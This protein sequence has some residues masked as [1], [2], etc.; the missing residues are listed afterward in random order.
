MANGIKS[1]EEFALLFEALSGAELPSSFVLEDEFS[2][3]FLHRWPVK[4]TEQGGEPGVHI[5]EVL[6]TDPETGLTLRCS[7]REFDGH[8]AVEWTS[9]LKNTGSR[10]TPILG[11]I[12]ALD[13]FFAP[14]EGEPVLHYARGATC[15]MDDFQPL[16]RVMNVGACVHLQP[17]GGRSSSDY[18]P[19]F[20]LQLAPNRGV[21][22]GIGW[23]GEWAATFER[24]DEGS[25]RVRI[26][27]ALTRLRLHP[28][29]EI[30]TPLVL[31]LFYEGEP[32][33]G[34]NALRRFILE[35]HRPRVNGQPIELPVFLGN[36]GGTPAEMHL[37]NIDA[38]AAHDLPA[39]FYWIDAEWFGQGPWYLTVGD[40]NPKADLYPDG[41]RPISDRLHET[42]RKLLLWFEPERV[43]QGT[44]WYEDLS[45]WLLEIPVQKRHHNWGQSQHDPEWVRWESQ[46]N[47]IGEGDRLF[48][49]GIPKARQFLTDHI[50]ERIEQ[51][52][53]D[54]YRHDA[55]IAPLEFWR[56]AGAHDRQGMAEIRW[57]EGLYAFWDE[58]LRRFPHLMIDNCASG[59]RRIDLET[60]SRS[61]PLWRTDYPGN[62]TGKQCHTYGI[63]SWIPLNSTGAVNPACD[64]DYALRSTF[65]ATLC[66]G[67]FVAGDLAQAEPVSAS[68]PFDR[69]K[70]ALAQYRSV[71][72]FFVGDY[73]P[74]SCYSQAA[75]AWMAWQFHLADA[76]EGMVQ[77]FRRPLSP[78]EEATYPLRGLDPAAEYEVLDID[79]QTTR[80][81]SGRRLLETGL[82]IAI[83]E[84]PGAVV[85]TYRKANGTR[86]SLT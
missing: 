64:S 27:Q 57:V 50:A 17:G 85:I 28:E 5:R 46:R 56:H 66:S 47:Q 55:N 74:L 33:D 3:E 31:A 63:A 18:L 78:H 15:S 8:T 73:Y 82:R 4:I 40:W 21:I 61:T 65:S 52:G 80:R 67:L 16:K 70:A 35:H 45:D 39:E 2:Y 77:A 9:F 10:D 13:T 29:E 53:L 43:C 37:S 38:I 81:C 22:F 75:D 62:L 42:G 11:D 30:R 86:S 23:S 54:C 83:R 60:L 79:E 24:S 48:N 20:N 7:V 34:Q 72:R 49:L 69:A 76:S 59:G 71:Q 25:V 12:Q 26:G 14:F 58:L 44:V 6:R 41:F 1:V 32:V 36:W 68:F 84:R 51:F 19:F